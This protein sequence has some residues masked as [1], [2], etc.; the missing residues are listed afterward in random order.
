MN[1]LCIKS[2]SSVLSHEIT[3]TCGHCNNIIALDVY[4]KYYHTEHI[5]P[6]GRKEVAHYFTGQ[7]PHCGNPIIVDVVNRIFFP[8]VAPFEEIQHLPTD[9]QVLFNEC[10]R[11]Y[12]VGAYTCCVITART[13][14]ANIAVEQGESVGKSFVDYVNF[15]QNNCLPA[16]TNNAWVDK[17]RILA[18]DATHHLV[19]AKEQDANIVIKFII[20]IL[21]NVYE[22]PN[23]I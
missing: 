11:A 18:N 12:S 17:I 15:L 13:L 1:K 6:M 10:K 23:S 19:I 8:P 14:M 9:I 4:A 20:A 7:C 16:K 3:C 21:K 2:S 5:S 22:F